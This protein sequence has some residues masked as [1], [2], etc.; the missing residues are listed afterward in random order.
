[1]LISEIFYSVQGEGALTGVPSV[2]IRT[3]GCNLRCTWCDTPYTSWQP[4]GTRMSVEEIV[5]I[6]M[7]HSPARHA[8]LTGGEPMLAPSMPALAS[9]LKQNGFHITIETAGTLPPRRIA[10]DLAS[11]SP[12]LAHSTPSVEAAGQAWHDRHDATR[13]NLPAL[14]EWIATVADYQLKFVVRDSSDLQEVRDL[15]DSLQMP[16]PPWRVHLMPEGTS[17][18]TLSGRQLPLVELCKEYGY[19]YCHRLHVQLFG[20]KRG[21]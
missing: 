11:I 6:A 19:R 3:A 8:V 4:E 15:L 7:L 17:M 9:L 18:E 1:M 2:F 20:H 13:L 14:R 12:K 16:V 5:R 10:C 21:T